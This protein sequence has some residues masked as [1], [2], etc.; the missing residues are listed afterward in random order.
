MAEKL[1]RYTFRAWKGED[2]DGPVYETW[3]RKLDS[4]A[5]A[6]L[7]AK[8]LSEDR[9][10][11]PILISRGDATWNVSCGFVPEGHRGRVAPVE[12]DE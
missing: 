4:D 1:T 11:V 9:G 2:V 3:V 8:R 5:Q 10:G 6:E 7:H 12:V